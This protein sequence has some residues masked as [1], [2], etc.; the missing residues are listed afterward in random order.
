MTGLVNPLDIFRCRMVQGDFTFF[1]GIWWISRHRDQQIFNREEEW[2][3]HKIAFSARRLAQELE[4]FSR[5]NR[6]LHEPE[7]SVVWSPPPKDMVK[8]NCDANIFH[9]HNFAGF[10]C[11]LRDKNGTWR[12]GC[13]GCL[14]NWKIFRCE[15]F[16]LWRDLVL[17]W[18]CGFKSVIIETDSMEVY[19]RL[20][21]DSDPPTNTD[22]DLVLKVKELLALNWK[23]HFR[24]V[25]RKANLVAN[26]LAEKGTWDRIDLVEWLEP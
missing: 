3:D 24:L 16:A 17:T 14:P 25:R 10:G 8:T 23:V 6:L 4:N 19:L 22:D 9:E 20:Q 15:L 26:L 13:S 7:D 18:E 12:K 11:L 2:S 5:S 21:F 1:A